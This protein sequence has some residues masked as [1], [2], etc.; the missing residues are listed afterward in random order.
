MKWEIHLEPTR[1]ML[2]EF[3]YQERDLPN[4]GRLIDL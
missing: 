4:G 3:G 1:R 2:T